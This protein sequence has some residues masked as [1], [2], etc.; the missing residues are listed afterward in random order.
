MVL[1]SDAKRKNR[2]TKHKYYRWKL[3]GAAAL[4]G[5]EKDDDD[6]D[7]GTRS[8]ANNAN[9]HHHTPLAAGQLY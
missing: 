7:D 2:N 4:M 6:D 3:F 1:A 9:T 8:S 5:I